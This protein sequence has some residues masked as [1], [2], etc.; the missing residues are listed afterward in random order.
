MIHIRVDEAEL[1]IH[2][3]FACGTGPEL[4][5]GD[6]WLYPSVVADMKADCPGCN[7]E[8]R[9]LGIPMSE[10]DGRNGGNE[11][12]RNLSESWGYP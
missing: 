12:W 7:P 1:N 3:R 2:R 9:S 5:D 8:P 6:Q 10:L 11:A 4:P